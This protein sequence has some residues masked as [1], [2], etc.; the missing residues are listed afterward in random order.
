MCVKER[1]R[2]FVGKKERER[3]MDGVCG[4]ER[5]SVC[6][7]ERERARGKEIVCEIDGVCGGERGKERER[8]LF[9]PSYTS[10]MILFCSIPKLF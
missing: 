3:K 4:G 6:E 1:E 2:V 5:E 9:Q 8:F 7:R 10:T